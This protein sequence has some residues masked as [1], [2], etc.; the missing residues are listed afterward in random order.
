LTFPHGN[1]VKLSRVY[2]NVGRRGA[3]LCATLCG[4]L[5]EI[6]VGVIDAQGTCGDSAT[7]TPFLDS[8]ISGDVA[9][10]PWRGATSTYPNG[11]EDFSRYTLPSL[12]ECSSWKGKRSHVDVTA[13]CLSAVEMGTDY[14]RGQIELTE[15]GGAF[16]AVALGYSDDRVIKWVD[17]RSEYRFFFH[18]TTEGVNRGFKVF[19]RYRSEDDLYVAS[20]RL[21]GVAQIQ[22][23]Q[24]GQ[25]TTLVQKDVARP[26]AKTWHHIRFDA[27]GD[28]LR[29]YLDDK[30][31]L[32]AES[33][34]FSWGTAGIRIDGVTGAYIDDWRVF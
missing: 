30:L 22:K 2:T 8:A 26:S 5:E 32:S 9:D 25:Y 24:C 16:R 23:K 4:C 28:H 27:I 33:A 3:L 14:S 15:D 11:E 13:G 7:Y 12:V 20:W 17:Q 21:D 29:L 19:A 34:T 10:W 31:V 1:F 18:G 6:E